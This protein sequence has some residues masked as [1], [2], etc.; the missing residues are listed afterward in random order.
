MKSEMRP[1]MNEIV[2]MLTFIYENRKTTSNSEDFEQNW[3]SLLPRQVLSNA[4]ASSSP[5]PPDPT[6]VSMLQKA[7]EAANVTERPAEVIF[8]T[9]SRS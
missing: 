1:S 3:S 9:I 5:I 2:A 4:E 8:A 6:S 7:I